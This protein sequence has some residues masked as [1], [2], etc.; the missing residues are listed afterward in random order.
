MNVNTPHSPLIN[1]RNHNGSQDAAH[2]EFPSRVAASPTEDVT[3]AQEQAG[4]PVLAA[5]VNDNVLWSGTTRHLTPT[6]YS[7]ATPLAE[8]P[9]LDGTFIE[10]EA[11][12]GDD[13]GASRVADHHRNLHTMARGGAMFTLE[14]IRQKVEANLSSIGEGIVRL[15]AQLTK[16]RQWD[17]TP[18]AQPAKPWAWWEIG[19]A[20]LNGV[21]ALACLFIDVHTYC[22]NLMESGLRTFRED[23]VS[24]YFYGGLALGLPVGL[25]T[26]L[27]RF[28]HKDGGVCRLWRGLA[29]ATV[30]LCIAGFVAFALA[31]PSPGS[32]PS[33]FGSLVGGAAAHSAES[34]EV[35][36]VFSVLL[37]VVTGAIS[38]LLW[39]NLTTTLEEHRRSGREINEQWKV[40]REELERLEAC[41]H[42]EMETL[43]AIE[44]KLAEYRAE[45]NALVDSATNFYRALVGEK[46][47][48]EEL[49]G[50][51]AAIRAKKAE[52]LAQAKPGAAAL[53]G[54]AQGKG[55]GRLALWWFAAST[56]ALGLGG[57][58]SKSANQAV[59]PPEQARETVLGVSPSLPREQ[60][61]VLFQAA[62]EWVMA[63]APGDRLCVF[64]ALH[65]RGV[66]EVAIPNESFYMNNP[67]A[68]ER[69]FAPKMA[70]LRTFLQA[71]PG[72]ES[73]ARV[74]LPQ[75]LSLVAQ[76]RRAQRLTIVIAGSAL[77]ANSADPACDMTDGYFPSDGH[78]DAD[79]T[80]S[81]FTTKGHEHALVGA[82]VHYAY[83]NDD[84]AVSGTPHRAGVQRF[85]ALYTKGL[86]GTLASFSPD[87]GGVLRAARDG[88]ARP[89]V[90]ATV[91]SDDSKPT[92]HRVIIE[93]IRSTA[94][95]PTTIE[96]PHGDNAE[97]MTRI[98]TPEQETHPAPLSGRVNHL[99]IGAKW[100]A[101]DDIDIYGA[102]SAQAPELFYGRMR[103]ADG[104]IFY[105]DF[106]DTTTRAINGLETIEWTTPVDLSTATCWLNFYA[107]NEPG[108]VNVTVRVIADGKPYERAYHIPASNGNHGE[109]HAGRS[110]DPHWVR[111]NLAEICR[112]NSPAQ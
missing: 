59:T 41:R 27:G 52:R 61:E 62:S 20:V 18:S 88:T 37:M 42:I 47:A 57:C 11:G 23:P 5:E 106:R 43:G 85:L 33:G 14:R 56:L 58:G 82:V 34:P 67:R 36:K 78:L 110:S 87:L 25:K 28:G 9:Q 50:K 12:A 99:I 21:G 83:T 101:H 44:G 107:G 39:H 70:V 104:G 48:E 68:R 29:I 76:Q 31:Y 22:V 63:A 97:Q 71:E 92:M 1:D 80:L 46:V 77:Y 32:A 13:A 105:K 96:E 15:R 111:V 51:I 8:M 4:I 24:A 95:Q 75:F 84:F 55:V 103:G 10:A 102:A 6:K 49:R 108:G 19:G 91:K 90:E 98:L 45:Q 89:V 73:S 74:V 65:L 72:G 112:L 26:L 64:D 69:E 54:R 109:N 2:A 86:G 81:P 38:A 35:Q 60:R 40:L 53:R 93:P 7:F 17:D 16:T 30:A 3:S 66:C 79:P 100:T 94:I